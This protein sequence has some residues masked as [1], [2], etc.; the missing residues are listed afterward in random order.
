M[1]K[2]ILLALLHICNVIIDSSY[3]ERP[4]GW[5]KGVCGLANASKECAL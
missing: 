1:I 4:L 3:V 2:I 5:I